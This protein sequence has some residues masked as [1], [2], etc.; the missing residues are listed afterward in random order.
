MQK[1]MKLAN[2]KTADIFFYLCKLQASYSKVEL[3]TAVMAFF[4]SYGGTAVFRSI[5]VTCKYI[6]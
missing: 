2:C 1:Y 5:K 6:K 4:L 3:K